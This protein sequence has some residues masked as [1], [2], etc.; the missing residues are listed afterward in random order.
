MNINPLSI[1]FTG[2]P[3]LKYET[4]KFTFDYLKILSD[5]FS[6]IWILFWFLVHYF[7]SSENLISFNLLKEE[8]FLYIKKYYFN[9]K[10]FINI[11]KIKFNIIKFKY[12]YLYN[13]YI[14]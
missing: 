3:Q 13:I 7:Y 10:L 5:F 6:L 4:I 12:A 1:P 2:D 11:I 8:N 14:N 9:K